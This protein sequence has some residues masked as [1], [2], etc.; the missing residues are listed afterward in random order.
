MILEQKSRK[1]AIN[2]DSFDKLITTLK[3][4]PWIMKV[5]Q[6]KKEPTSYNDI[7]DVFLGWPS[8]L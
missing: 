3:K 4:L 5:H 6:R 1:I 8:I 2:P 7:F